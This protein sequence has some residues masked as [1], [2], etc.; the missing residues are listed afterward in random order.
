MKIPKP[1]TRHPVFRNIRSAQ[2]AQILEAAKLLEQTST[3]LTSTLGKLT[4]LLNCRDAGLLPKCFQLKWNH[5]HN[6]RTNSLLISSGF[7][8]LRATIRD[9]RRTIAHL[10]SVS[11]N[12]LTFLSDSLRPDFLF[13]LKHHVKNT[14]SLIKLNQTVILDKKL[15][16]LYGARS[17]EFRRSNNKNMGP[18]SQNNRDKTVV[19]LS[20]YN[21]N[22]AEK[23]VLNSTNS[24]PS[25]EETKRPYNDS[26]SP[27]RQPKHASRGG[28][29]HSA[30]NYRRSIAETTKASAVVQHSS[31]CLLDLQPAIICRESHLH[32]RRVKEA[33]FIRNNP[34]INHDKGVEV[35]AVQDALII[36]S[37]CRAL[38][39]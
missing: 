4:F 18:R 34:T 7:S 15:E 23:V 17:W 8:L 28:D 13:Q 38:P 25:S 26:T 29:V 36:K 2:G 10:R 19:N 35:S 9:H 32:L 39:S 33:L 30:F 3:K 24:R 37:K 1:V 14:C 27:K 12:T 16:S 11:N 22:D 21:L 5:T 6:R 31:Q 20:S